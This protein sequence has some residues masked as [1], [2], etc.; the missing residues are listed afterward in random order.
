MLSIVEHMKKSSPQRSVG[1]IVTSLP[2]FCIGGWLGVFTPQH[3]WELHQPFHGSF[4]FIFNFG[5]FRIQ[6][7]WSSYFVLACAT[8]FIWAGCS[9]IRKPGGVRL[10]AIVGTISFVIFAI[11]L[12]CA[13]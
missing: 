2:F 3:I 7:P 4:G 12:F 8:S 1:R 13:G 10:G 9:L 6:E 5:L 11:G